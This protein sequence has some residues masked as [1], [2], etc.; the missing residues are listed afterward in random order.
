MFEKYNLEAGVGGILFGIFFFAE[1]VVI[2]CMFVGAF[3]FSK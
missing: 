3:H 1:M 2:T